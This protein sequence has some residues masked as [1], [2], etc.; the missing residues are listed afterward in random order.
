MLAIAKSVREIT[1]ISPAAVPREILTA[2]EPLL[3][4]NLVAEWPVVDAGKQ[5]V[6]SAI[7]YF[8]SFYQD[9]TVGAFHGSPES[10]GRVF[11]NDDMSGFSYQKIMVKLDQIMR[12]L[13]KHEDDANAPMFYVGSTTVDTC[14][15][16]FRAAGNDINFGDINPLASI[17]MGNRSR[18]AAHF[19]VPDNLACCAVGHRRFTLFPPE[20]LANLYIGPLDFTP[21][22]QAIS[23]V[24]FESPDFDRFPC[25]RAALDCAQVADLEPGDAI[26]VPS[27]WW[28][29]VESLD[30]FNVLINY[31]WRQ[32]PSYMCTPANVLTHAILAMRDLPIEQRNAWRELLRHYVFDADEETAAHIPEHRRGSLSPLDDMTARRLR[33]EL[34]N[35]L[36]R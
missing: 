29:H 16:G 4:K 19:D 11:Y 27:M 9:A 1:G 34:L 20:Q 15:P 36:N 10:K 8:N 28:H 25:F 21:A 17:W 26:F 3:L 5:S 7:D 30:S 31:W 24:D 12:E 33:A 14:L 18:I 13:Q 23:M 2:T 6:R 22:G 32:S 35:K